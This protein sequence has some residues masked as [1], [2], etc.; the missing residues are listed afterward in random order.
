MPCMLDG[1]SKLNTCVKR[2]GDADELITN[3]YAEILKTR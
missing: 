1:K 3:N 2:S